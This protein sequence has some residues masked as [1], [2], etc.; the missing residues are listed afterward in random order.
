MTILGG[1]ALGPSAEPVGGDTPSY[2]RLIA[3]GAG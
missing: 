1:Q 2:F 3:N